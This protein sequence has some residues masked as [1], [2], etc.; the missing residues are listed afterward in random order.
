MNPIPL[1][2]YYARRALDALRGAPCA[3]DLDRPTPEIEAAAR[4]CVPGAWAGA[5]GG[6]CGAQREPRPTRPTTT[7]LAGPISLAGRR[8]SVPARPADT[9]Y[10]KLKRYGIS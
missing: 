4:R 9:F 5:G 8:P 7:D 10:D 3:V 6:A 1:V 2:R